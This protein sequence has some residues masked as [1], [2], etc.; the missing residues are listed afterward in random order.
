M[1]AVEYWMHGRWNRRTDT[2]QKEPFATEQ[3]A[4]AFI[5]RLEVSARQSGLAGLTAGSYR[6]VPL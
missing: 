2:G 3:D 5:H 6:V 4:K 1:F